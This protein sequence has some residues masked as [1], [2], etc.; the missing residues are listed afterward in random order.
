MLDDIFSFDGVLRFLDLHTVAQLRLV[1]RELDRAVRAACARTT[2]QIVASHELARVCDTR[3]FPL[4]RGFHRLFI[5]QP[6]DLPTMRLLMQRWPNWTSMVLSTSTQTRAAFRHMLSHSRDMRELE[7]VVNQASWHVPQS[8]WHRFLRHNASLRRLTLRGAF[9]HSLVHATRQLPQ[10]QTLTLHAPLE[11]G[12]LARILRH[13]PPVPTLVAINASEWAVDLQPLARRPFAN[14]VLINCGDYH[15]CEF[16][17]SCTVDTLVA[18]IFSVEVVDAL[19]HNPRVRKVEC[20]VVDA[21]DAWREKLPA[22]FRVH[23]AVRCEA[24]S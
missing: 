24:T 23:P 20:S 9:T 14:L 8:L 5:T 19:A 10:L 11:G 21:S 7:L 12:R 4:L 1:S 13:A 22:N 6:I 3:L 17:E 16:A 18:D 2:L 15:A